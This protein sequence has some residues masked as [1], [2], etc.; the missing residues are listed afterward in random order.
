MD[1]ATFRSFIHELARSSEKL[2]RPYFS[3]PSLTVNLKGDQTPVTIA[4][5]KTEKALRHLIN[6]RYP[7]HGIIGEEF[8][9]ENPEADFVWVLDPIDGTKTFTSG[10]PLFGTLI[11]LLYQKNPILGGI[12]LPIL[13]QLYIGDNTLTTLNGVPT[14][15]RSCPAVSEATLLL[16]DYTNIG[17]YHAQEGFDQLQQKVKMARTWGDCYGYTLLA[18]GFADIMLDPIMNPWDLLA[19]IPVIQGAGGTISDWQGNDPVKGD[20]IVATGPEI[21]EK[22]IQLLNP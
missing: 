4:D 8:G 20:S 6:Q 10:C 14:R 15:L 11:C 12:N 21:H 5:Q 19:L 22:V 9:K 1:I 13:N 18:S 2:I 17:K 3:D 16:T 7:E